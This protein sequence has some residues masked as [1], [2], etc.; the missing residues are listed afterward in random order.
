[1]LK[2]KLKIKIVIFTSGSLDKDKE[3]NI[4]KEFVVM[5]SVVDENF[6]WYL[7]DNIKTYCSEPEKIDQDNED[8][9][10]S[11]R[12]YC[13]MTEVVLTSSYFSLPLLGVCPSISSF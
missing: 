11:N 13:K 10:E 6:S 5:F 3:K 4:D 1:M 8:F 7:E 12:M 9:Q 2:H